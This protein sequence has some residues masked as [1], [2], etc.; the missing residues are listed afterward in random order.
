MTINS[1]V[2]GGNLTRDAEVKVTG[3]DFYIVSFSVAVNERRRNPQTG[4]WEDYASYID[5]SVRGNYAKALCDSLV[6]GA[7]VIV[8]GRIHQSRW[9]TD[10]GKRSRVEVMADQIDVPKRQQ[11]AQA[12]AFDDLPF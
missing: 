12:M 10:G 4:E 1:V 3:N 6:K 8:Q 5:C 2:I 11:A 7:H 9:E